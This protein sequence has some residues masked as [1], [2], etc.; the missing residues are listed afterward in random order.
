MAAEKNYSAQQQKKH[1]SVQHKFLWKGT[2]NYFPRKNIYQ[3]CGPIRTKSGNYM[4]GIINLT[5]I[6][7][8][9]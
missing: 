7:P 9:G 5:G 8:V 2:T 1:I 3:V 4:S 6:P